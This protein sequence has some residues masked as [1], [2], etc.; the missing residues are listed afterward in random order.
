MQQSRLVSAGLLDISE[1][2]EAGERLT[3]DEKCAILDRCT[4]IADDEACP[5]EPECGARATLCARGQRRRQ[6]QDER[7]RHKSFE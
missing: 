1:K 4:A 6:H 7:A 3:L 5:F 2:L